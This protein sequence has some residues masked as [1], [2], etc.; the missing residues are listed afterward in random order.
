MKRQLSLL[1]IV[2]AIFASIGSAET[3]SS[4]SKD[5]ITWTFDKQYEVGR[6]ISGD[7]WVVGPITIVEITPKDP[8]PSDSTAMHGTM[9][10][11]VPGKPPGQGFDSRIPGGGNTYDSSKNVALRVPLQ[12]N[13]GDALLSSMSYETDAERPSH[14]SGFTWMRRMA[15]LTIVDSAPPQD[16]FR[17][18]F[19]G[20]RENRQNYWRESEL[21]YDV[22]AKAAVPSNAP[23]IVGL[24]ARYTKPTLQLNKTAWGNTSL[25]PYE[26]HENYGREYAGWLAA[27][28]LSLN[29]NYS[30]AQKRDL[31]VAI[32]Q[33]GID[34]YGA[35]Q[36]GMI[37]QPDGGHALG[38]KAP[39]I[40]AAATLGDAKIFT[41][42]DGSRKLFQEDSQIFTLSTSDL[43][44]GYSPEDVDAQLPEWATQPISQPTSRNPAWS[45][46][47]RKVVGSNL[48]AAALMAKLMNLEAQW[49]NSA[50][51][52]Y[53]EKRYIVHEAVNAKNATNEI[54]P[55][56][57]EMWNKSFPSEKPTRSTIKVL[58]E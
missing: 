39:T 21:N 41:V 29:M 4:V 42:C 36:N 3:A 10:N 48:V 9:L 50:F 5:G 33:I 56:V 27:G 16:A 11:P 51:F 2:A 54:P 6:F 25:A 40:L 8:D 1:I 57:L 20:P 49:N 14:H 15:V 30:N 47:Y 43:A 35:I 52:Q 44:Y 19:Y 55:W 58:L 26:N 28:L 31:L 17:P 13:A 24:A 37:F 18:S 22:L 46:N 38:R 7:Y 53:Y 12:L 34:N 45:A 23:S 32:V